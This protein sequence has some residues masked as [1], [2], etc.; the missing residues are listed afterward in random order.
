VTSPGSKALPKT[1]DGLL[2]KHREL[3]R[4]RDAAPLQSHQ[5]AEAMTEIG[6]IEVEIARL[7]RAT[8]PPRV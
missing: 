3:R 8:D 7:D 4:E 5:R 1:R 2:A 6:R